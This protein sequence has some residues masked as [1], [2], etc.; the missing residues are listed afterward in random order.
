MCLQFRNMNKL[1][2]AVKMKIGRPSCLTKKGPLRFSQWDNL[3]ENLGLLQ[4]SGIAT[5]V[6]VVFT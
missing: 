3:E 6:F 5:T 2:A 1:A 4:L